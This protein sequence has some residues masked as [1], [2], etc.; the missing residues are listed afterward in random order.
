MPPC[1]LKIH[2]LFCLIC[3]S[4]SLAYTQHTCDGLICSGYQ[5][6]F[7]GYYSLQHTSIHDA[8][9]KGIYASMP[10]RRWDRYYGVALDTQFGFISG[11]VKGPHTFTPTQSSFSVDGALVD[12]NA[13]FGKNITHELENPFFIEALINMKHFIYYQSSGFP[14]SAIL[15]LGVG[16]SST[17]PLK[18]NLSLTYT[19]SYAYGVYAS[20]T[21]P[22]QHKRNTQARIK[23]NNHEIRA[24]LTL[25]ISQDFYT[26]FGT[27]LQ[28]LDSAREVTDHHRI[29]STYPSLLQF[30]AML[31]FG[32]RLK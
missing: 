27:I 5:L 3:S 23:P 7:G 15:N 26:R 20:H 18:N 24:F 30:S 10:Y 4:L 22:T 1:F 17:R 13:R 25:H 19:L 11:N 16:I 6:G 28:A 2:N 29:A 9:I 12:I 14:T 32:F 31:E 8:E 21:Y